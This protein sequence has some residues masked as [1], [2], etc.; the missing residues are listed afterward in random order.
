[1]KHGGVMTLSI[2]FWAGGALICLAFAAVN[3][4]VRAPTFPDQPINNRWKALGIGLAVGLLQGVILFARIAKK[5][6]LRICSLDAPRWHHFFPKLG[7]VV[8]LSVAMTCAVVENLTKTIFAAVLIF[9]GLL[10]AVGVSLTIACLRQIVFGCSQEMVDAIA[11][12]PERL[13]ES[14]AAARSGG[15]QPVVVSVGE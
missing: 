15:E 9:G 6:A 11:T 5:E 2:L 1:M 7:L 4:L 13:D 8:V 10:T 3:I 12:R 14:L